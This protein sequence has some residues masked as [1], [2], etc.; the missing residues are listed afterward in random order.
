MRIVFATGNKDKMREIRQILGALG[1]D[2]VSMKEADADVDVDEN[3]IKSFLYMPKDEIWSYEEG[4]HERKRRERWQMDSRGYINY[5]AVTS[6]EIDMYMRDRTQRKYY[7]HIIPLLTN[8]WKSKKEEESWE[9]DFSNLMAAQFK[10]YDEALVRQIISE[11]I[12]WWREK[13]IYIRPLKSDDKKSWRMIKN[14]VEKR[15]NFA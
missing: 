6:T 13:V 15:L 9:R 2:V 3:G 7:A 4:Y 11:A 14:Y 10:D 5:D 12:V 8:L 1:M